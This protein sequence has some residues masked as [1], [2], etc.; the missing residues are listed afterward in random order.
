VVESGVVG[1]IAQKTAGERLREASF[2]ALK[3]Q[4]SPID[5]LLPFAASLTSWIPLVGDYE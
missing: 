1:E 3:A 2:A 4:I 5:D